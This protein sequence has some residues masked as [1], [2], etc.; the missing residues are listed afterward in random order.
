MLVIKWYKNRLYKF[1]ISDIIFTV[2]VIKDNKILAYSVHTRV[3]FSPL[4]L[5]KSNL[6]SLTL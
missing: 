3:R 4:C 6:T 1:P 5:H 2:L